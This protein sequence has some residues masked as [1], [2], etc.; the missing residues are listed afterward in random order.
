MMTGK[1]ENLLQQCNRTLSVC[2]FLKS[3]ALTAFI[4]PIFFGQPSSA[5]IDDVGVFASK[6]NKPGLQAGDDP[7]SLIEAV[8]GHFRFF[9]WRKVFIFVCFT[10]L[11]QHV[12]SQKS[13]TEGLPKDSDDS[14]FFTARQKTFSDN[15]ERPYLYPL[16]TSKN[17]VIN[18]EGTG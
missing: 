15:K 12:F 5:Q 18:N 13:I 1:R 9:R 17:T 7:M 8:T 2:I 16:N 10:L 11:T 4:L 14:T 6:H 3:K